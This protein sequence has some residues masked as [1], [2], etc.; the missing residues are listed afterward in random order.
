MNLYVVAT[1]IGNLEDISLRA[2]RVLKEVD[3]ILCEDTRVTK[4]LLDHY[5]IK[6]ELLSFHH[7]SGDKKYIK[8]LELLKKGKSLAVVSDAGTPNISDPGGQLVSFVR[9]NLPNVNIEPIP[10]PSALISAL[11][12]SGIK[13]DKFFFYGFLPH[14]KGRSSMIKEIL[15]VKYPV[16]IYESK[17]RILKLIKELE[18]LGFSKR[19]MIFR[20]LTKMHASFYGDDLIDLY[21]IFE[22]DK[23][24]LKGEFTVIIY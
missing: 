21:K 3:L 8:I 10:G 11:S 1:P 9:K 19:I 7:H 22:Q 4:K 15:G 6:K 17:H 20:E 12:V 23:N 24:S 16:V 18:E 2:L 13:A 5:K 14:K